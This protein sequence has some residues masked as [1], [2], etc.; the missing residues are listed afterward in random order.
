MIG[1][2]RGAQSREPS[3]QRI[4]QS[5]SACLF[6]YVAPLVS[7]VC[8]RGAEDSCAFSGN[9]ERTRRSAER[10][11]ET[12]HWS[13]HRRPDHFG[14]PRARFEGVMAA[15]LLHQRIVLHEQ[16]VPYKI[17]YFI[18]HPACFRLSIKLLFFVCCSLALDLILYRY[19]IC[20]SIIQST[21]VIGHVYCTYI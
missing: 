17:Y 4:F 9:G 14:G 19:F 1:E 13:H 15:T 7:P 12:R 21:G 6:R 20:N 11:V 18:S 3:W 5:H 10:K 16:F 2:R 8:I